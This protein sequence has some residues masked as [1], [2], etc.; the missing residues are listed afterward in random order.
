M[1]LFG[2]FRYGSV[3][4]L[5]Q[6]KPGVLPNSMV[7]L[8]SSLV[9]LPLGI[10]VLEGDP[11][12]KNKYAAHCSSEQFSSVCFLIQAAVRPQG[13]RCWGRSIWRVR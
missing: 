9:L 3:W 12:G 1:D 7:P 6:F 11:A 10:I 8:A 2:V 13:W 4:Q 5:S